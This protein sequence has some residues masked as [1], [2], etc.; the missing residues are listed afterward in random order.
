[1]AD[2]GSF[3]ADIGINMQFNIDGAGLTEITKTIKEIS[4][5]K[6]LQRYWKDVE[7]ATD[8][9]SKAIE[10]YSKNV[11]S[12]GL[13][14]NLLKQINALKAIT[15]NENLSELFPNIELNLDELVE[16]AKKLVP[17]INSEFSV[18]SFSQAFKTFDLLK[19][20]ALD[21]RE[22]FNML[23]NYSDLVSRNSE[24]SRANS[25]FRELIGDSDVEEVKSKLSEIKRLRD[26]AEE[27]FTSFLK[28][29][30]IERTDYWG[31]EKFSDYFDAIRKGSLT[32]T[33]AISRFKTEYAYL[34]EEGFKSNN[35]TFGLE[36]LQAFSNKLDSIFRQVEETS[37]KIND[38][39]S[40]G[41]ITKSV[42][43]LSI[44]SS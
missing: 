30:N 19:E 44:D 34:L 35:D 29:N 23:A 27:I 18:D 13:A 41:V 17:K 1:M 33:E 22:V 2:A 39:I 32:A 37:T 25:Q 40:N 7:S 36:Q 3:N 28:I 11:N 42:E 5:G 24:L 38:I 8:S 26:Q 31:D 4:K 21:L 20:K 6:D 43:N 16:S 12:K 14:E 10:R 9:A 15:K